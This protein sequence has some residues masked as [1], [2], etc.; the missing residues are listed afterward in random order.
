MATP[1]IGPLLNTPTSLCP[2]NVFYGQALSR[3]SKISDKDKLKEL[4]IVLS[5]TLAP[6]YLERKRIV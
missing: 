1:E 6:P 5:P 4:T 3:G 2:N